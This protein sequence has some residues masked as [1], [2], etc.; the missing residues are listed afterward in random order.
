VAASVGVLEHVGT[1]DDEYLLG[2]DVVDGEGHGVDGILRLKSF[3]FIFFVEVLGELCLETAG[4]GAPSRGADQGESVGA[5]VSGLGIAGTVHDQR[6]E[7]GNGARAAAG[8]LEANLQYLFQRDRVANLFLSNTISLEVLLTH[9]TTIPFFTYCSFGL[10]W[11][12][13][14]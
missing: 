13:L 4:S 1:L 10:L 7:R 5:R 12:P 8:V 3:V 6:R 14:D 11:S 9:E 2:G